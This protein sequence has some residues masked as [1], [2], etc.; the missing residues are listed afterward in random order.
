MSAETPAAGSSPLRARLDRWRQQRWFRWG[1]DLVVLAVLVGVVSAW[2]TRKNLKGVELPAFTLRTLDG[3][4][5]SSAEL[6]GQPTLLAFWAPW[7]GVCKA[8]TDNLSRVMRWAGGRGRVLSMASAYRDE[9]DVER[10]VREHQVDYPVL[11]GGDEQAQAFHVEAYPTVYFV[12]AQGRI[13][14][15]VVGYTTTLGL[16]A[17]LLL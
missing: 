2:Q 4:T 1:S 3:K 9:R 16:F 7:C 11:L 14:G 6:K 5:V 15:S 13:T 12:D 8:E 17:R 10:Y